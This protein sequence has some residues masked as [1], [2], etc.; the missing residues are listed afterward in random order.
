[1]LTN[2][3]ITFGKYKNLTLGHILKD[4]NYCKWLEDQEW[5]KNGYE[6]LYNCILDYE[7]LDFFINNNDN[8]SEEFIESYKFF[9][10]Y[11][12]EEI[13]LP[14][15][16]SEIMCYTYYVELINHIKQ[17]I[18]TRIENEE[19]NKFN[20]KAPTNWLKKFE[21]KYGMP[22][23]EFKNFLLSYELPNIPYIIERIKSEGGI[24]YKGAK[25]FLIAKS[26]S[27]NQEK[28]WE[29]ILHLFTFQTPIIFI[30]KIEIKIIKILKCKLKLKW[31]TQSLFQIFK[32]IQR[33]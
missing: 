33:K 18:Y 20:I 15:T 16:D 28:W 23:Q 7:P 24:E 1:M 30:K 25:S 3:T 19:E 32:N 17:Q 9:N 26:R 5:F 21:I 11:K 31:L 29:N 14:L 2:E 27:E 13:Q 4:R 8:N 6:Y 10:L 12:P 22:R